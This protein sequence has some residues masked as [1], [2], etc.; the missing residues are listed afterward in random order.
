MNENN[1]ISDN[2]SEIYNLLRGKNAEEFESI[3]TR[4][5]EEL[6]F[7]SS[8]GGVKL[9]PI[10][11]WCIIKYSPYAKAS[12]DFFS[13]R[14]DA[15]KDLNEHHKKNKL[16]LFG[17]IDQTLQ[18]VLC[19]KSPTGFTIEG[20]LAETD[21]QDW[22][23]EEQ[24]AEVAKQMSK[25]VKRHL[26]K[27]Q[28]EKATYKV[29]IKNYPDF[30]SLKNAYS[31][32]LMDRLEDYAI[33]VKKSIV[34][35]SNMGLKEDHGLKTIPHSNPA[36]WVSIESD[37]GASFVNALRTILLD[38]QVASIAE[39]LAYSHPILEVEYVSESVVG[40]PRKPINDNDVHGVFTTSKVKDV[41]EIMAKKGF[42]NQPVYCKESGRCIGSIRLREAM[43]NL[44][45]GRYSSH[46][47]FQ[48]YQDMIKENLMLLPPPMF[49]PSDS[50]EYVVS[51][52]NSGCEAVLFEFDKETWLE[53][54]GAP[55][56]T[57][58]LENGLHI[59]TPHD[60]VIYFL[61][62]N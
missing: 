54:G 32:S 43:K 31:K 27:I 34:N 56:V 62:K 10:M 41:I 45:L 44:Y 23:T 14:G 38:T 59:L 55:E 30:N 7:H 11:G 25:N 60:A 51:I 16:P 53:Y 40:T 35:P 15:L 13:E 57:E 28:T 8:R 6:A 1:Q 48:N 21:F 19:F 33:T 58:V 39:V 29:S 18:K 49:S 20:S 26:K 12:I 17:D 36:N 52:F 46:T 42:D 47:T 2:R 22:D 4:L 37:P 24:R 3:V 61:K 5:C 50:I 9:A